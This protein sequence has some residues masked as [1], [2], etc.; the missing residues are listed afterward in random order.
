MKILL[1]NGKIYDGS[2]ALPFSGDV[3]IES[4][5]IIKLGANIA[6]EVDRVIDCSGLCIT[7]G[8]I[9]A[10]THNDFFIE[11]SDSEQFFAPFV[12]QGI[13]TQTT[14]NCGFSPFGVAENSPH[15]SKI[16]NSLFHAEN[17]GSFKN[18]VGNTRNRLHLNIAPLIG[19]GSIRTG[20]NGGTSSPLSPSDLDKMLHHV[21]EAM[22]AGAIGGSFGLEYEPGMYAPRAEL[23]AFAKEIAKYNGI[24]TA[25]SRANSKIALAYR[26]IF[27]KPHIEIALKELIEIVDESKVKFH[28]SHLI[29]VGEETWKCYDQILSMLHSHEITYDIFAFC[30]GASVITIILPPWYLSLPKKKRSSKLV[31]PRLKFMIHTASKLLGLGFDD[32]IVADIG[33]EYK[34]Y[35]GKTIAESA[36][37]EG[38][39]DIDMYIK[40]VEISDGKA[41]IYIHKYN[42]DNIVLKLMQDD[43]SM[44]MTDAW[45][46][47]SGIQ[48]QTAF[49]GMPYFLVRGREMGMPLEHTIHK[50]TGKTA[51]RFCLPSRGLLKV[52]NFADIT[53][54]DYEKVNVNL[55]DPT[56]TPSGIKYVLINGN[57][58][59]DDEVYKPQTCGQMI[60]KPPAQSS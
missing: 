43:L 3:L 40:L 18:F 37:S 6:S 50:M 55:E 26:P 30:H 5:K 27:T 9:D 49:Q 36:K 42:N 11:R 25:H 57:M 13:T 7:P 45:I 60:L 28:Y 53:V 22:E 58:V 39:S 17:P 4:D 32:M 31:Q 14:G 33:E 23:I 41:R 24:L 15:K 19:H 56:S 59:V 21:R 52:G 8:F 46:E 38:L 47:E 29:H 48:N 1:K 10:H 12:K 16:G 54:F 34:T 51:E 35:L 2:G 20:I 44:F